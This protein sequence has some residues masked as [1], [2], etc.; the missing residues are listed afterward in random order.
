MNAVAKIER[1]RAAKVHTGELLGRGGNVETQWKAANEFS[2]KVRGKLRFDSV[3]Q[4]WFSWAGSHWERDRMNVALSEACDFTEIK[5]A[6]FEFNGDI[7]AAREFG[8]LPTAKAILAIAGAKAGLASDPNAWDARPFLLATP[9]GTVDLRTGQLRAA[10]P[11]DMLTRC[12]SVAPAEADNCPTWKAFLS[13]TTMGDQERIAYIQRWIGYALTGDARE[14]EC[15][16]L[17]GE[18][19]NGK[20]ILVNAVMKLLGEHARALTETALVATKSSRHLTDI[21]MLRGKRLA[22]ASEI[23]K[24]ATWDQARITMLVSRDMISA[25]RMHSDPV[26]FRPTFKL[27]VMCNNAPRIVNVDAAMRRRLNVMTFNNGPGADTSKHDKGLEEKVER[28]LPEIFRWAINGCLEWQRIGLA[29]PESVALENE[30]HFAQ[31]DVFGRW[32][33]ECCNVGNDLQEGVT[34]LLESWS[35]FAKENGADSDE[36]DFRVKMDKRFG[37]A[38]RTTGGARIRRGVKL[39]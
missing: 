31:Q 6:R 30:D 14:Q 33:A 38:D 21:A 22:V 11:D 29:R 18:G 23:N 37:K 28:E 15:L 34:P 24:G 27:S 36:R 19:G 17:V 12:T 1:K 7:A 4:G 35:D 3:E 32:I 20:G 13:Q 5:S 2:S 10:D 16:V 25:N 26:D 8:R 9:R 39:K